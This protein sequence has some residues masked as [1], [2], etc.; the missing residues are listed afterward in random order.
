ML[1]LGDKVAEVE[2]RC[3]RTA[4]LI[5]QRD[6]EVVGLDTVQPAVIVDVLEQ[7]VVHGSGAMRRSV[8]A[9]EYVIQRREHDALVAAGRPLARYPS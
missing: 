4:E 1:V 7:H 6:S 2:Q 8:P 9:R 5:E 3:P